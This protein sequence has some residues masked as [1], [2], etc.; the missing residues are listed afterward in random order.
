MI[1]HKEYLYLKK[2]K[3]REIRGV[4]DFWQYPNAKILNAGFIYL[5]VE[6][7]FYCLTF[8][9]HVALAAY[10][11]GVLTDLLSK[12]LYKELELNL[13]EELELKNEST[14]IQEKG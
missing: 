13:Y 7:G 2:L 5:D 1:T 10:I 6:V 14:G 4:K 12:N 11:E 9:G 8:T 3:E